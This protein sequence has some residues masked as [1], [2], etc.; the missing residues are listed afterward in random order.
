MRARRF[1]SGAGPQSGES[2][3]KAPKHDAEGVTIS[4]LESRSATAS[5]AERW[6]PVLKSP[7]LAAISPQHHCSLGNP[8][9]KPAAAA[10]RSRADA[11]SGHALSARQE[12][13]MVSGSPS[14]SLS[15]T[16]ARYGGPGR[17]GGARPEP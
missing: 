5:W 3:V 7:A 1:W 13:K 12:A 15:W 8:T 4:P 16:P 10:I 2:I 11:D 6:A 9:L 14:T 17:R